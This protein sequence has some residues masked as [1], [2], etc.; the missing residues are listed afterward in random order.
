MF[1]DRMGTINYEGVDITWYGHATFLLSGSVKVYTDPY[2]L[3]GPT[4]AA[5][6]VCITH[7]HYDHCD[8]AKVNRIR[9]ASTVIVTTRSAAAKLSGDVQVIEPGDTINVKGVGIEAVHAYNPSKPF[10][11]KGSGVGFIITLDGVR[12]YHAGDTEF[13]PEMRNIKCDVALLPIGG[14]YTMD[15]DQAI[16]A[17][18]VIRPKLVIPMHYGTLPE[19]KADPNEY[20]RRIELKD[21]SIKVAVL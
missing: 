7:D 13:V 12:I 17:A 21:P 3:S 6:I 14:T 4:P 10:H 8:P 18:L 20:K 19:T 15:V 2:V 5:D 11:P 1:G 16:T 9:K